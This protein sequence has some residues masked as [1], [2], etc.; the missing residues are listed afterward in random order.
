ML[1]SKQIRTIVDYAN[2]ADC[3]PGVII[4]GGVCY[5]LW[6]KQYSGLCN[7]INMQ[8]NKVISTEK[9]Y[10][11]EYST[12]VRDNNAIKIIRKVLT[13]KCSTL[14]DR[15]HSR[16]CFNIISSECGHSIKKDDD[17]ILLSLNGK[18]YIESSRFEDKDKIKDKYKVIITKAMSG[19]NKPTIDG[20][21]QV[22]SSLGI[23]K[24]GEVCTETYL[25]LDTFSNV[26]E[27]NSL[28]SYVKTKFFRFLLLQA[29]T[30]INIS[31][32]KFAFIPIVDYKNG[33][34][35]DEMLYK[36]YDL[37]ADEIAFIESMIRPME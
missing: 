18:S 2:S 22:V 29:L 31:K 30:S 21:Y 12:F 14:S 27:A 19:G 15:V 4:A 37:S 25:C 11:N 1:A 26:Q 10:L 9:R 7:I 6:E 5:F 32:D 34:W 36:K 20:N 16:N 3:F 13:K 17:V 35:T 24:P 8:Q 23:L 28:Y 33:S